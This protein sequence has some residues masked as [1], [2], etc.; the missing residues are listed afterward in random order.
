[1]DIV[2]ELHSDV[3]Y[4]ILKLL[5]LKD[6]ASCWYTCRRWRH[7]I[8]DD[9][10]WKSV[11]E[12]ST[13]LEKK[14]F[15]KSGLA[16]MEDYW[17]FV[18]NYYT[19]TSVTWRR[20]LCKQANYFQYDFADVVYL[21]DE[22]VVGYVKL[23]LYHNSNLLIIIINHLE[24]KVQDKF[25][26]EDF[27]NDCI[28]KVIRYEELLIAY[29]Q[30]NSASFPFF[31]NTICISDLKYDERETHKR[32]SRIWSMLP[33][34]QLTFDENFIACLGQSEVCIFDFNLLKVYNIETNLIEYKCPDVISYGITNGKLAILQDSAIK[35]V[36]LKENYTECMLIPCKQ[37]LR[38][39]T[40]L[41]SNTLI[42]S[43]CSTGHICCWSV[44]TKRELQHFSV[45]FDEDYEGV[46]SLHNEKLIYY[47][48][49][50]GATQVWNAR[51]G[52]CQF[53]IK[54]LFY[55]ISCNSRYMV[56]VDVGERRVDLR[57]F[58]SGRLLVNH[59]NGMNISELHA[60]NIAKLF[61][62]FLQLRELHSRYNKN[63]NKYRDMRFL[64]YNTPAIQITETCLA[65]TKPLK[66][67]ILDR[68]KRRKIPKMGITVLNFGGCEL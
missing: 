20:G 44:K 9:Y 24:Q 65:I 39:N 62:I 18:Y 52:I 1:M 63:G 31:I 58:E 49:E 10:F 14:I 38:V 26:I 3:A 36:N 25:T 23:D 66:F 61:R 17:K 35:V 16:E 32:Y 6:W 12:K 11:C 56:G 34:K 60:S 27:S 19:A 64:L 51:T 37:I 4:K 15:L 2:G 47:D 57:C 43:I 13:F 30:E 42:L 68:L 5:D 45:T 8:A 67:T 50:L 59:I 22:I 53:V 54:K 28:L 41:T 7:L 21:D 48:M 46:L 33:G 55:M 29:S 40:V